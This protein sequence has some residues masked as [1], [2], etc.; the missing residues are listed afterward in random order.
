MGSV[1]CS[2]VLVIAVVSV[3]SIH[4]WSQCLTLQ[5]SLYVF[6]CGVIPVCQMCLMQRVRQVCTVDIA[7]LVS[8]V[9]AASLV[10]QVSPQICCCCR[11]RNLY[12]KSVILRFT[13]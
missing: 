13:V 8:D 11:V 7:P 9:A 12:S 6:L 3:M 4:Q 2:A 10:W 1:S 5:Y